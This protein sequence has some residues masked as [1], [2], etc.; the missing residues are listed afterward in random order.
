MLELPHTL[1]GAAIA[2]R[3]PQPHIALP[4]AFISHFLFDLIPHWNPSLYQETKKY[5]RPTK[6]STK[7]VIIDTSVSLLAGFLIASRFWPDWQR[8]VLIILACFAAVVPDVVEGFYFFLGIRS[9]FLINLI[10][11]QHRHQGK[12]AKIPGLLIQAVVILISFTL[13]L[14]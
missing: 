3:I 5:G 8:M 10:E 14:A 11:F 2:S 7:I 6:K 12:A 4:L 1:V 13:A 9:K